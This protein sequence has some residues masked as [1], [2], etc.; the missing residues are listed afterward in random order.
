M[1]WEE[2][3]RA[4]GQALGRPQRAEK[5]VAGVLSQFAAARAAH[6]AFEGL[7]AVVAEQFDPGTYFVRSATD[8]RTRFLT[9]LG[10]VL[11]DEISALAGDLDGAE[12]STE[13]LSLLDRDL[14]V[15]NVG[16]TPELPAELRSDPLYQR[17]TVA[18]EGRD[19][20][21]VDKVLS[22]ALTWSTVLS[23]S[24]A[25]D[26]LVPML[27]A[28]VD[29][30]P[31]TEVPRGTRAVAGLLATA[32]LLPGCAAAAP[33]TRRLRAGM[34]PFRSPS[35]TSSAAGRR[36]RGRVRRG[37]R[38][39]PGV[40]RAQRR[41]RDLRRGRAVQRVRLGGPARPV[42]HR[43]GFPGSC[44]DRP[45]RRRPVLHRDQP[46]AGGP[47]GRR[48]SGVGPAVLHPRGPGHG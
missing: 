6:P 44:R 39:A 29:G 8:P 5:L 20:F 26:Q 11:P 33:T 4:I 19:V 43:T 30:D 21:L 31:V 40:G 28:A 14:L 3:T 35:S 41:R 2:T 9:S 24:L 23:L 38:G 15:W 22:G 27:A 12:I 10:F 34:A 37:P 47:A 25:I 1:P 18:R 42:L 16:F 36:R 32:L 48:P 46:G 13:Q 45:A 17:L 7:S